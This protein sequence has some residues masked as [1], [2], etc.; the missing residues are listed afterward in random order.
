MIGIERVYSAAGIL[1]NGL[2]ENPLLASDSTKFGPELA[3]AGG[4]ELLFQD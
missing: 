1:S 2:L 3:C 4:N